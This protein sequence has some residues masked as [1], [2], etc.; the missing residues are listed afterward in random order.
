MVGTD[1][2]KKITRTGQRLDP[3]DDRLQGFDA[4]AFALKNI[5]PVLHQH[6]II[7][8]VAGG[9][10]EIVD[11]GAFRQFDPYFRRDHAFHVE[12]YDFH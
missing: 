12:T 9:P 7:R 1:G 6:I 4:E 3:I 11:P 8:L 5:E 2:I 10:P